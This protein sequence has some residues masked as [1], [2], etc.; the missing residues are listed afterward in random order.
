MFNFQYDL[1]G[2][3][4]LLLHAEIDFAADHQLRHLLFR[5]FRDLNRPHTPAAPQNGAHI[6]DFLDF[7]QFMRD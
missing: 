4:G 7:L 1:T 3:L 6:G 2:L 5:G